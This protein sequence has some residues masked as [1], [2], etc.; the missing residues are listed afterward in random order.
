M[1]LDA[2]RVTRDGPV[3]TIAFDRVAQLNAFTPAMAAQ[4]ASVLAEPDGARCIILTGEGRAFSSGTELAKSADGSIELDGAAA[5]ELLT[6]SYIPLIK[7]MTRCRVP[8]IS[9][10]NGIAAGVGCSVALA[11]D[12][13]IAARS[14]SFLQAFVNVGLVPDGGASWMLPRLVGKARATEMMMLGEKVQAEKAEAWG[15][16]YRTVDDEDLLREAAALAR[17][18]AAGPTEALVEIRRNL[19]Y[20]LE[21]DFGETMQEEAEVQRRMTDSR[22]AK[23][24]IAAFLERRKPSF[25]SG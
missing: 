19:L 10:V 8:I 25:G 5:Y 20:A 4:V 2:I 17:R 14:A 12:F 23:E 6:K 18:L 7:E 1:Q 21:H 13:V 15:M 11:A 3:T 9:A 24:G 16:I 22:G